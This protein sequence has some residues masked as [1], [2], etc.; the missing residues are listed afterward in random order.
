MCLILSYCIHFS[1]AMSFVVCL[2]TTPV[3]QSEVLPQPQRIING[4]E[5]FVYDHPYLVLFKIANTNEVLCGGTIINRWSI[6]TAGHCMFQRDLD[7][8]IVIA[9]FNKVSRDLQFRD[10]IGV[11][12]HPKF[13]QKAK[14]NATEMDIDYDYAIV[15]IDE[16]LKYTLAVSWV[17]LSPTMDNVKVG[18]A[19]FAMGWGEGKPKFLAKGDTKAIT[20]APVLKGV[21]LNLDHFEECQ[22]NYSEIGV[23]VSERFFCASSAE[24]DTCQGD[25]GGP[26]VV[27]NIQ[28]GLVSFAAGCFREGYPSVFANIPAAYDWI[29]QAARATRE[30]HQ[31]V[32]IAVCV[33][34]LSDLSQ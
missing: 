2:P 9:G 33:V 6:L 18:D 14:A 3:T 21:T 8:I 29:M 31:R 25:S 22:R 27:N 15:Q 32:L 12:M 34:L 11:Q 5:V 30:I 13:L 16:P 28:Y 4:K 20:G 1:M 10:V 19:M 17:T 7:E 24:G 26:I 23:S